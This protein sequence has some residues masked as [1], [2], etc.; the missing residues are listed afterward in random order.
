[1]AISFIGSAEAQAINGGNVTV[2]L[3]GGMQTGDVV[4]ATVSQG[5]T[6]TTA[7]TCTSSAGTT[8]TQLVTTLA[9]SAVTSRFSV[10]RRIMPAAVETQILANGT[11]GSSDACAVVCQVFRGVDQ[12]TPEDATA[13]S[14]NGSGTTPDSP[15]ITV[16]KPGDAIISCVQSGISDTTVTA[17]S[18]FL[19]QVDINSAD[20]LV[21][22][23]GM[24]WITHNSSAAFNPT[25]WSNFTSAAWT[26]ATVA[27]RQAVPA[28]GWTDPFS[29]PS[30]L[31]KQGLL[32]ARQLAFAMV[33]DLPNPAPPFTPESIL[34]WV[35]QTPTAIRVRVK[36]IG[37]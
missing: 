34:P 14:T 4:I 29:T 15:S 16:V 9:S 12:T 36:T 32:T 17:P 23:A 20:T 37:T 33:L 19:N 31:A 2:T 1:M 5:S 26:S 8:Y 22:T 28:H 6:R 3:P 18:S 24:A 11:G 35:A 10:W 27:L 25:S 30:V 7:M 13:T 21:T